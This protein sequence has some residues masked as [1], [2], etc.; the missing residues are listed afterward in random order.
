M[1]VIGGGQINHNPYYAGQLISFLP[2]GIQTRLNASGVNIP[3][4]KGVVTDTSITDQN[5][6]ILP[7]SSSTYAQFNGVLM[8]ELDRAY[9]D[10][11]V[12][13]AVD[14]YSCDVVSMGT[15]VVLTQE[16]VT[17]DDPVYL[18]TENLV[19]PSQVGDFNTTGVVG[20]VTAAVQ[21]AN[22]KFI[23]SGSAGD[24]VQIALT[25]GG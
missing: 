18:I 3:Y 19:T 17:K 24:L 14:Q 1:P 25:I 23:T 22:A 5:A 21:I 12:F 7:T 9:A 13:G 6:I 11:S 8:Y 4:G 20:D 10:N 15:I 2:N 16:A